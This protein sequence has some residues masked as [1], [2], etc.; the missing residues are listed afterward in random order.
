VSG[1]RGSA[2]AKETCWESGSPFGLDGQLGVRRE[3]SRRIMKLID[4]GL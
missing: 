1:A 3:A 2:T 4:P